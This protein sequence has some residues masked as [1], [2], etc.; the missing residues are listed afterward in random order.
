[1]FIVL[2]PII[3][4]LPKDSTGKETDLF[5]TRKTHRIAARNAPVIIRCLSRKAGT[6]GI[7][8]MDSMIHGTPYREKIRKG[9]VY[10]VNIPAFFQQKKGFA[11]IQI[12]YPADLKQFE[13]IQC[14]DIIDRC[15][16][17]IQNGAD[18]RLG[19]FRRIR[20]AR[21]RIRRSC[22]SRQDR[23]RARASSLIPSRA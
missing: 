9:I 17:M 5:L 3:S 8:I 16:S 11:E 13:I 6:S 1:M 20:Q 2:P 14:L 12:K 22:D 18:N 21:V 19:T 10:G 15:E 7:Q 4:T 23:A